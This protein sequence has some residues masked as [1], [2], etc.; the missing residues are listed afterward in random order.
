MRRVL[1][2]LLLALGA[3]P[4]IAET[5]LTGRVRGFGAR[6]FL[7]ADDLVR[8]TDATPRDQANADLRLT[9]AGARAG[10]DYELALE[11]GAAYDTAGQVYGPDRRALDLGLQ[12]SPGAD[13]GFAERLDRFWIGGELGA[14]RVT[15]G[16]QAASFGGG[17][18]FQP[19]DLFNPFSPVEIDRDFKAGDD[20]IVASRPFDDGS[21][22]GLFAVA[23]RGEGDGVDADAGS[24]AARWRGFVGAVSAEG[25]VGVHLD[26]PLAAVSLSGPVGTAIWRLDL[27]GQRVD[28]SLRVSGMA[29][30]D[31]SFVAAGKN[32]YVFGELYRSA[33]G[34]D[35]PSLTGLQA[36]PE[37]LRRVQRGELFVIGREYGSLGAT[38]EWHPLVSQNLLLIHEFADHSQLVQTTVDWR[39]DD[40]SIWQFSLVAPLGDRGEEFGRLVAGARADGSPLTLGGGERVLVRW[41]LY[42]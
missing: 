15:L 29:N 13:V 2:G 28:G 22:I 39:P 35:D 41:S 33:F 32:V 12:Q 4:A 31:W 18:V 25:L 23:R 20:M 27:V 8:F 14:W 1:C 17:L 16:R 34:L 36:K 6:S 3:T 30:L 37:L 11:L 42:F 10:L 26:D 9:W 5:E 38:V 24:A 40:A 19:M 21:E 7:P